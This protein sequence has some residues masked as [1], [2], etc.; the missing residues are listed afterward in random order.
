VKRPV[1]V[2]VNSLQKL[3]IATRFLGFGLRGWFVAEAVAR[4]ECWIHGKQHS[5]LTASS[6]ALIAHWGSARQ[7]IVRF[8]RHLCY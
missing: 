3:C 4:G 1:N 5:R 7:A 6:L 8:V 2:R